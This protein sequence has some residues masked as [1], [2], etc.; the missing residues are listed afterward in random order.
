MLRRIRNKI[1]KQEK[2]HTVIYLIFVTLTLWFIVGYRG[3]AP[4]PPRQEE[5]RTVRVDVRRF[6]TEK[7]VSDILIFGQTEAIGSVELR[8]RTAGTVEKISKER[9]KFARR[10]EEIFRLKMDDREARLQ[11]QTAAA[12]QAKFNFDTAGKLLADGFIS[13]LE[14][15]ATEASYK[16]AA[17]AL[18]QIRLDIE[19]TSIRA[20]F[21][22]VVDTLTPWTGQY[23]AANTAVGTFFDL[24]PIRIRA[25]IPE[26]YI[27]RVRPNST[28]KI[29]FPSGETISAKL[30]Y[31]ASAANT[32]TRTF[33]LE[34]EAPNPDFKFRANMTVEL[35]FPLDEV[36]ATK[37]SVSSCLTF[38]EDGIV[39]IKTVDDDGLVR[40]YPVDL[41][42]E[43]KDGLW[44]SGLPKN[45][46]VIVA[47]QEF[48]GAGEKANPNFIGE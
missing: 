44:V 4:T 23:I 5:A 20:P 1:Q 10:G 18:E 36:Y 35:R 31:V 11:A 38:S 16:A 3:K 21:D 12:A 29:T 30:T 19:F 47:G 14:Y 13:R 7:I 2:R 15:I 33:A 41:V 28:A 39:G 22:G 25:E 34:L 6:K 46:L 42:R 26:K 9:G 24:N 45:A 43:E 48:V 17:A 27:S 40:F 37:I 32:N 8:T